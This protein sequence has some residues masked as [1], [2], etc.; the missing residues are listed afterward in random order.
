M[1]G[2]KMPVPDAPGAERLGSLDGR[3]PGK[4]GHATRGARGQKRRSLPTLR[5][6]PVVILKRPAELPRS[7]RHAATEV[8]TDAE[9]DPSGTAREV[10]ALPAEKAVPHPLTDGT[11]VI[12]AR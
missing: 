5:R 10:P 6:T 11:N 8:R 9:A 2:G 1:L 12:G 3:M 4:D 7:P